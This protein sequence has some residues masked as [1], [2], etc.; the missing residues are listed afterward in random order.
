MGV[1]AI[2]ARGAV[3]P[4]PPRRVG[5]MRAPSG[6]VL[7]SFAL[8]SRSTGGQTKVCDISAVAAAS[9]RDPPGAS[10]PAPGGRITGVARSDQSAETPLLPIAMLAPAAIAIAIVLAVTR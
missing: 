10:V 7:F 1:V 3:G 6:A 9:R 2:A 4:A 8:A 5:T